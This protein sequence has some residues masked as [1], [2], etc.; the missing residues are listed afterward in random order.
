VTWIYRNDAITFS[1]INA[2]L[3]AVI[4]CSLAW[5]DYDND[6]DLDLAL[7]GDTK[8]LRVTRIYHNDGGLFTDANAGLKGGGHQV[9]WGDYDN[10]GDLDIVCGGS[11]YSSGDLLEYPTR[12]Y[13]NNGRVFNTQPTAPRGLAATRPRQDAVTF[14]WLPATDR[15]TPANGLSYNLRV[16]RTPG[17]ADVFAGM[18]DAASGWRRVSA[19]GNAQ[20]RLSWTIKGLA[21]G[22]YYWSV[23]AI[24]TAFA[25]SPWAAEQGIDTSHVPGD[26][27]DDGCVNVTDMLTVR[28]CLG[29]SGSGLVADVCGNDNLVNVSDLL[30]VRN[31]LGKGVCQ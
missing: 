28:N 5:G 21:G 12:I 2:G 24:D 16:G 8:R 9:A 30:F 25:G 1:D 22:S 3:P 14:N 17:G 29:M 27:N 6:G 10:D 19:L 7:S 4:H 23:Q 18:A 31:Q 15:E 13:R 11:F 20:K 26:V